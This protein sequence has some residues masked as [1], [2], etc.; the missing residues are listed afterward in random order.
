M[1]GLPLAV[2]L[3]AI[4]ASI[5]LGVY[6]TAGKRVLARAGGEAPSDSVEIVLAKPKRAGDEVG[7]LPSI[8]R[9]VKME[10]M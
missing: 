2:G 4:G 6:V 5:G 3:T 8:V 7:E 1:S 10:M 9:Y